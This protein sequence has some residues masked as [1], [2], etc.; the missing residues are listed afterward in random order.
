MSYVIKNS[1]GKFVAF[2]GMKS[3]YTKNPLDARRF[4]TREAAQAECCGN[5]WPVNLYDLI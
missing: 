3:S 5:E 2:P 1:N 4:P